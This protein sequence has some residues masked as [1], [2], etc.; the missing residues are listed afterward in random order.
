MTLV[1][2]E[3]A[4]KKKKNSSCENKRSLKLRTG[5]FSAAAAV[6]RQKWDEFELWLVYCAFVTYVVLPL[7]NGVNPNRGF[8]C[9]NETQLQTGEEEERSEG[10][11]GRERGKGCRTPS[12]LCKQAKAQPSTHKQP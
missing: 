5:S 8:S 2:S 10:Q 1:S 4:L 12:R 3:D 11:R 9:Q 7:C 6:G